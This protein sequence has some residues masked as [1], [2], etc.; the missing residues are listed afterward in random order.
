MH[1]NQ[2]LEKDRVSILDFCLNSEETFLIVKNALSFRILNWFQFCIKRMR[3]NRREQSEFSLLKK[4]NGMDCLIDN[5]K[6]ADIL[7][8]E[9]SSEKMNELL[10]QRQICA[11]DIRCLDTNSK[12]CLKNLCLEACLN[13]VRYSRQESRLLNEFNLSGSHLQIEEL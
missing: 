9:I 8:F 6:T 13:N 11:A 4:E 10:A 2:T 5:K 12:K 1:L 3:F 7:R